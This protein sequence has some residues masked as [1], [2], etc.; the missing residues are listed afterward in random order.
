[1][2]HIRRKKLTVSETW[3]ELQGDLRFGPMKI[4]LHDPLSILA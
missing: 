2:Q 3:V 1:M 4:P